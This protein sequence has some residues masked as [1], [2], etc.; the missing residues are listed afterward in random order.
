MVEHDAA[1]QEHLSQIS[2]TKFVAEPTWYH[3]RD[4]VTRMLRPVQQA[5]APF[6]ELLPAVHRR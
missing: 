3:E 4:H 1:N 5:T 6:V 2:Q